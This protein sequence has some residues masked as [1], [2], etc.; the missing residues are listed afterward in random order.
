MA[1][2]PLL[3]IDWADTFHDERTAAP[4]RGLRK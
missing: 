3:W 4:A 1:D 2:A